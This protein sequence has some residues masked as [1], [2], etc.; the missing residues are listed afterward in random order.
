MNYW[1]CLIIAN[2]WFAASAV[3]AANHM[4]MGAVTT[5]GIIGAIWAFSALYG[6]RRPPAG[7]S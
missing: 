1:A 5:L 4:P 6:A 3:V 2:I 7:N